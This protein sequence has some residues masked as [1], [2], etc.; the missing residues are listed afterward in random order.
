MDEWFSQFYLSQHNTLA[1]SE[2]VQSL[3]GHGRTTVSSTRQVL[4]TT[5][6]LTF[7]A[8]QAYCWAFVLVGPAPARVL[9]PRY[10]HA[11]FSYFFRSLLTFSVRSS[12]SIQ[13]KTRI[14]LPILHF[15]H[16]SLLYSLHST[17]HR[18][19]HYVFLI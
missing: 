7:P 17:Y 8:D 6:T 2:F 3:C 11:S 13:F 12:L 18:L 19:N 9:C 15:L 16:P 1:V 5:T 14:P 10:P 4:I